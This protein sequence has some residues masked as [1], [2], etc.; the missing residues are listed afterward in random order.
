LAQEQVVTSVSEAHSATVDDTDSTPSEVAA[1]RAS[2]VSDDR[3]FH[4][5]NSGRY[6][7]VK[8][9]TLGEFVDILHYVDTESLFYHLERN[10]F[11]N[12]L[13]LE[14]GQVQLSS[15]LGGV[16]AQRLRGE[17]LRAALLQLFTR[18]V[19]PVLNQGVSG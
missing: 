15:E 11:S 3:A 1:L 18:E 12:W 13:E 19:E 10:D 6:L 7:G 9:R 17:A 2:V 4:F 16:R 5:W 14:L 8:A